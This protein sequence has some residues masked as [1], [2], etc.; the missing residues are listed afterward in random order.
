MSGHARRGLLDAAKHVA[1]RRR[2]WEA[3]ATQL[4]AGGARTARADGSA[5][6]LCHPDK[7]S[8]QQHTL[9]GLDGTPLLRKWA[10]ATTAAR[11][12]A[13]NDV[14]FTSQAARLARGRGAN[15][16]LFFTTE[17]NN[18]SPTTSTT[19]KASKPSSRSGAVAAET[20]ASRAREAGKARGAAKEAA[21]AA[22]AKAAAAAAEEERARRGTR[23]VD[24]WTKPE[25]A[26]KQNPNPNPKNPQ[27][28]RSSRGHTNPTTTTATATA[29]NNSSGSG[30]NAVAKTA[31]RP[32]MD[33]ARSVDFFHSLRSL[34]HSA[35]ASL[36]ELLERIQAR[37]SSPW[38]AT[39]F[40]IALREVASRGLGPIV[41]R[42]KRH[43]PGSIH[44]VC[45]CVFECWFNVP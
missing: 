33:V 30:R 8:T 4:T 42:C 19:S 44:W 16:T 37:S 1:E 25:G 28:A 24:M 45:R 11:G 39:H 5:S 40:A 27:H 14:G 18:N 21:A 34:R 7:T 10:A 38:R 35:S 41:Q 12:G 2:G 17:T 23:K 13:S 36:P 32:Y 15:G 9:E 29:A 6:I 22:A 26:G 31:R 20:A 3:A 43:F